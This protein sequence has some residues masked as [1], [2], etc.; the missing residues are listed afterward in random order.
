ML[1][2]GLFFICFLAGLVNSVAG[3]GILVVF[4]T[5]LAV[6]LPPI[7]ANATSNIISWPGALSSAYGYRKHLRRLPKKYILLLIPCVLG[8]AFGA[9]LLTHTDPSEFRH[10]IPWLVLAAVTLFTIQPYLHKKLDRNLA[11]HRTAPLVFIGFALIPMAVYGG[12]FGAGFGF[13]M[14]AFLSFTRL[15][16]LHQINGLKNLASASIALVCTIYFAH[17]HLIDWEY[18]PAMIA[19]GMLGGYFG[20]RWSLKVDPRLVH[21]FIIVLGLSVAG[22][23]FITAYS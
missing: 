10:S 12:Y 8:A 14:L 21:A 19:G 22:T 20:S 23:L 4:P 2:T 13:I 15:K 16:N 5:L 6:G 7:T 17:A 11:V 18:A 3:G 9:Y 1:S